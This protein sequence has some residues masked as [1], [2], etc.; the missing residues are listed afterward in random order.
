MEDV[1]EMREV[2]FVSFVTVINF[3]F[4]LKA[5]EMEMTESDLPSTSSLPIGE[6]G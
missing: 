2:G 4:N 6:P 3:L 1:P 5:R